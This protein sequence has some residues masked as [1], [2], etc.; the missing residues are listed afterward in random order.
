MG[1]ITSLPKL[2]GVQLTACDP[3]TRA[4]DEG[5]SGVA[6]MVKQPT[7]SDALT[8]GNPYWGARAIVAVKDTGGLFISVSDQE[9]EK[10]CLE[11]GTAEGLFLEPAGAASLAGLY[12]ALN[13][14]RIQGLD[15][16]VCT[17]TGHGLNATRLTDRI[18]PVPE[19]I[20]P[21][22]AAVEAFLGL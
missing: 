13:E 6:P 10:M 18:Q 7:I 11:L 21:E 15:R 5:I 4:F 20:P 19:L 3:V 8:N 1:L 12:K 2:I 14:N 22:P 9:L 17:V 16:V